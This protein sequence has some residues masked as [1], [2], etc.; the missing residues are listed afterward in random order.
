MPSSRQSRTLTQA[1]DIATAAPQVIAHRLARMAL[2]GPVPSARDRKEFT[3]MVQEK[4]TAFT[5]GWLAW[6]TEILRWQFQWQT[7]WMQACLTGNWAALNRM[8]TAPPLAAAGERA[9]AQAL[10]PVRRKAAANARRLA[11]TSLKP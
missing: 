9:L 11:K 8:L 1:A 4:Q 6:N 3:A 2:A 7:Q 5:Q 10:E